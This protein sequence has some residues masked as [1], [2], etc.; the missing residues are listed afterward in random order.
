M[1]SGA[2]GELEVVGAQP[3]QAVALRVD[4][5]L[6]RAAAGRGREARRRVQHVRMKMQRLPVP[7][8][9]EAELQ[10]GVARPDIGVRDL[11]VQALHEDPLPSCRAAAE[12]LPRPPGAPGARV[13]GPQAR[14]ARKASYPRQTPPGRTRLSRR[15]PPRASGSCWNHSR[16]QSGASRFARLRSSRAR[17]TGGACPSQPAGRLALFRPAAT[18]AGKCSRSSAVLCTSN[19]KCRGRRLAL[20]DRDGIGQLRGGGAGDDEALVEPEPGHQLVAHL[21]RLEDIDL[22]LGLRDPLELG[23]RRRRPGP[24]CDLEED[25]QPADGA[26][27][28]GFNRDLLPVDGREAPGGLGRQAWNRLAKRHEARR[29]LA[30]RPFARRDRAWT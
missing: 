12:A 24:G 1:P 7:R 6:D 26:E 15:V 18:S 23:P 19:G 3:H 14:C 17:S 28:V 13:S 21:R 2:E 25:G 30:E 5:E 10:V 9:R 8:E 27:Q 22:P 16:R 11:V 20:L 4:E 29:V